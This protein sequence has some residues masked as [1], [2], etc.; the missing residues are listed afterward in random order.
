MFNFLKKKPIIPENEFGITP[1]D[2]RLILKDTQTWGTDEKVFDL[3]I[4]FSLS[5]A[6]LSF[7]NFIFSV[8][9]HLISVFIF[10]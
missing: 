4:I 10:S 7:A 6:I 5:F 2:I 8:F 3:F 1:E 9:I